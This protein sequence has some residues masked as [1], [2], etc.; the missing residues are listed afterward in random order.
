MNDRRIM[1]YG[2]IIA[3]MGLLALTCSGCEASLRTY[4]AAPF[5]PRQETPAAYDPPPVAEQA[6]RRAKECAGLK[7]AKPLSKIVWHKMAAPFHSN[8]YDPTWNAAAV[9]DNHIFV[10]EMFW[11]KENVIAHELLHYLTNDNHNA[12]GPD[13]ARC[14]F[15]SPE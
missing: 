5:P 7:H 14:G 1:Q 12:H 2:V 11:D 10:A 15:L 8:I 9:Y 4:G 6:Y 3:A 13:Y